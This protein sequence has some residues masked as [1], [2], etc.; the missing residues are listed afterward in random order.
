MQIEVYGVL[1]N[2]WY[3]ERLFS[4]YKYNSVTEACLFCQVSKS[5]V[6]LPL[7]SFY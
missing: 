6:T 3:A 5:N 7:D 2:V 1:S 4:Q